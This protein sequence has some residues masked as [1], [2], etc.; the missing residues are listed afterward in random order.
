MG[1]NMN[2]P[3]V[4]GIVPTYNHEKWILECLDGLVSQT[5]PLSACCVVV[6]GSKDNTW[7]TLLLSCKNLKD[8]HTPADSE[9]ESL[10]TG[11]YR[12]LPVLLVKFAQNHGPSVS[13]NY[14][15]KSMLQGNEDSL[16]AF[17]DSDDIYEPTK[18]EKSLPYFLE[19]PFC[20]MVYSD[21]TT[22][23][24]FGEQRQFK[25]PY[26]KQ[27]LQQECLGN[28]D[29]LFRAKVFTECGMFDENLTSVEDLDRY[30]SI[31]NRYILCHLAKSLVKIRVGSHSSSSQLPKQ[32]WEANYR[33]VMEKHKIHR[34]YV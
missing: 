24:E 1:I 15:I 5:H 3:K 18:I 25:E 23:N 2:I 27:R 31:S 7:A 14:S 33:K 32:V 16:F 26:S 8:V 28:M 22:F 9:P 20:G 12:N 34:V 29:S 19:N 10:K 6:D 11:T 13:R 17:C 4:F 21:Y 30:L